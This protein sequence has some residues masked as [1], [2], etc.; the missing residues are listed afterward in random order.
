A[1]QAVRVQ[2]LA[3]DAGDRDHLRV[4]RPVV[5]PAGVAAVVHL[6]GRLGDGEDVLVA[7]AGVVVVPGVA[8]HHPVAAGVDRRPAHR[9]VVAGGRGAG[10]VVVDRRGRHRVG[11]A[12]AAD[13]R[14][15]DALGDAAVHR[16]GRHPVVGRRGDGLVNV[17][18]E[19]A[20]D[21][22]VVGVRAGPDLAVVAGV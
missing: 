4:L 8:G 20:A 22:V 13:R 6:G 3:A 17:E 14:P 9:G 21:V 16:A 15:A 11:V 12:D 7:A 10:R 18:G 2:H 5:S 1:A 19:G